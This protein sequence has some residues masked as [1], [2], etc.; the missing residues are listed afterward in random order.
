MKKLSKNM[1][2]PFLNNN[3]FPPCL[4]LQSRKWGYLKDFLNDKPKSGQQLSII[5]KIKCLNFDGKNIS[6]NKDKCINCLFCLLNC[7]NNLIS[8]SKDLVLSERCS[9]FIKEKDAN[10]DQEYL[11]SFFK[12]KIISQPKGKLLQNFTE[13]DETE[14]ISIWGASI[15][16]FLSKEEKPRLGLEIKMIIKARDRGGRLDICLLSKDLL[17]AI[18][19]KVSFKKMVQENRY[20]SQMIAYKE[21]IKNNLEELKLNNIKDLELLLIDGNESDLL[22]TDHEE[23]TSRVGGQSDIFYSNLIEHELFFISAKAIWALS[24]KKLFEDNKKYCL[25]NVLGKIIKKGIYGLTT[26]GVIQKKDKLEVI[27][28]DYFL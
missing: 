10:L 8:V 20:V 16:N 11:N 13:I 27:P 4:A 2:C 19:T 21:E 3:K 17:F 6:I 25:E 28:L 14:N 23:C 7:P 18:E 22:F 9:E 26:A 5:H 12:G 1:N 15:F 24:L